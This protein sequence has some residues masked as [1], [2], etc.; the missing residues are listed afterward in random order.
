M[1][2]IIS[3]KKYHE[4]YCVCGEKLCTSVCHNNCGRVCTIDC[5]LNGDSNSQN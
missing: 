5:A 1:K 4:A 3:G 2:Y